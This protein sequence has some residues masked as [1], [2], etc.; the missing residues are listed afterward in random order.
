VISEAELDGWREKARYTAVS[1]YRI[2]IED[3]PGVSDSSDEGN[4]PDEE[5]CGY[6]PGCSEGQAR[7]GG[8]E[9]FVLRRGPGPQGSSRKGRRPGLSIEGTARSCRHC[10]EGPPGRTIVIIYLLAIMKIAGS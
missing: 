6:A 3:G 9:A 5:V 2:V 8:L 4:M 10:F 7:L 1:A